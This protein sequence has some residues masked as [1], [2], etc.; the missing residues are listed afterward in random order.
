[1][2]PSWP[3]PLKEGPEPRYGQLQFYPVTKTPNKIQKPNFDFLTKNQ[4]RTVRRPQVGKIIFGNRSTGYITKL[5]SGGQLERNWLVINLE[6]Y[7]V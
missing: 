2:R 1:M 4:S 7:L 6:I 3:P 5:V